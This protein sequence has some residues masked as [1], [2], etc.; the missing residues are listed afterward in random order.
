MTK[1]LYWY[2]KGN[3]YWCFDW[4]FAQ[5]FSEAWTKTKWINANEIRPL[6]WDYSKVLC[7]KL[8]FRLVKAEP[9]D[10][11]ILPNAICEFSH[12][13]Y[14]TLSTLI[15][16]HTDQ[17]WPAPTPLLSAS[18][19]PQENT[20][21]MPHVKISDIKAQ[22]FQKKQ[23]KTENTQVKY[24]YLKSTVLKMYS[25]FFTL[26]LCQSD[27]AQLKMSPKQNLSSTIQRETSKV[28]ML[29]W[30]ALFARTGIL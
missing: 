21:V 15:T 25:F 13:K 23:N 27:K 24:R 11:H 6:D 2:D 30:V 16:L 18:S 22:L 7:H 10:I 5:Y 9:H 29:Y 3:G 19:I 20:T 28:L 17:S 1:Y 12:L 26:Y 14:E 4:I 8:T